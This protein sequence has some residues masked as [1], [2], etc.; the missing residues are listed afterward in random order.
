GLGG[1]GDLLTNVRA[2]ASV[3]HDGA[4]PARAVLYAGG[5]L[6]RLGGVSALRIAR[7]DGQNW[8][9]M[10]AGANGTVSAFGVFDDGDG[11]ALFAGGVF[12]TIDGTP[13]NHVARWNGASW[14]PLST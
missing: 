14:S 1:S 5:I 8:F 11:A 13:L 2:I 4:G 3:D 12:T 9:P 6:T 10:G 7:W